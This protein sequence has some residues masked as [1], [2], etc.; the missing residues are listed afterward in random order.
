VVSY[1]LRPLYPWGKEPAQPIA[2]EDVVAKRKSPAS[3]GNRTR[4]VQLTAGLFKDRIIQT[5][6]IKIYVKEISCGLDSSGSG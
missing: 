1:T 2:K 3:T 6:N 4:I 5:H